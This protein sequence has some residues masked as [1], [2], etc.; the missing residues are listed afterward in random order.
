MFFREQN[1]PTLL[2]KNRF[3]MFHRN[4]V[5]DIRDITLYTEDLIVYNVHNYE[6]NSWLKR[7]V[8]RGS[9]WWADLTPKR[10]KGCHEKRVIRRLEKLLAALNRSV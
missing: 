8:L 10:V 3:L 5:F 4:R 7:R 2:D 1:Q 9:K 6:S